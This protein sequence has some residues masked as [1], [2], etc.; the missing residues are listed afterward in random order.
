MYSFVLLYLSV[1]PQIGKLQEIVS[2]GENTEMLKRLGILLDAES[3]TEGKEPCDTITQGS[4][5]TS[6]KDDTGLL[7]RYV[8]IKLI[9]WDLGNDTFQ[10]VFAMNLQS[11]CKNVTSY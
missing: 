10:W 9:L 5:S 2:V 3:F 6:Q 11:E 1:I 7:N 8:E 4:N